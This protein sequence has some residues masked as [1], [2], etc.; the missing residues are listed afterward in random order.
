M[1][2]AVL[3]Q[4][5]QPL[6]KPTLKSSMQIVLTSYLPF[7]RSDTICTISAVAPVLTGLQFITN[8]F[9]IVPLQTPSV[10]ADVSLV[11]S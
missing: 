6:Q 3:W 8:A 11:L 10:M 4:L 5:L 2:C 7:K 1:H 9:I